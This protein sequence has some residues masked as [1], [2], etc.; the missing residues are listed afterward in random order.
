MDAALDSVDVPDDARKDNPQAA[1]TSGYSV[2]KP[3]GVCCVTDQPIT[4]DTPYVAALQD[5]EDG[6]HRVD[7]STAAWEGLS[8][9]QQSAHLAHWHTT[10]PKPDARTKKLLV[11]DDVLLELFKRLEDADQGEKQAFRFML[12]LML[13]RKRILS[14]EGSEAD[15]EGRDVWT[16]KQRKSDNLHRM[17]DP[18]LGEAQL[19]SVGE[20][21]KQVLASGVDEEELAA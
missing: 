20:Q 2:G 17:V 10:M 3:R 7:Y 16:M 1:Q 11:D 18:K 4:P 12:G 8:P 6:L 13:M 21:V 14:F 19:E 5:A 15:T 9:E